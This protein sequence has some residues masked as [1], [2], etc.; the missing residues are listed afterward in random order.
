MVL[1]L[2]IQVIHF[3]EHFSRNVLGPRYRKIG[4]KLMTHGLALQG[5]LASDD[6]LVPSMRCRKSQG[7]FPIL[8]PTHFVAPN[9]TIIGN[10]KTRLGVSIWYGAILRSEGGEIMLGKNSVVHDNSY[11]YCSQK[12]HLKIGHNSLVGANSHLE[13]CEIGDGV[14]VGMS[15][16]I[17]KGAKMEHNSV[18]A[19][20]SALEEGKVVKTR[21][22]WGG[23]PARLIRVLSSDELEALKEHIVTLKD[24]SAIH[25]EE[26]EKTFRELVNDK[27]AI[28]DELHTMDIDE[29]I[30]EQLMDMGMP[31]F[32]RDF[33]DPE[34][35][36]LANYHKGVSY[37]EEEFYE[38]YNQIDEHFPEQFKYY[39]DNYDKYSELDKY[40]EENPN[41]P[42]QIRPEGH[43]PLPTYSEPWERRF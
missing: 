16:S 4:Q 11:L 23:N 25:S 38:T 41:V 7:S 42:A 12:C 5:N 24:L 40:F 8:S 19:P 20:G 9:A 29:G 21:E 1:F 6:R 3:F 10:V 2:P 33:Q 26:T 14:V 17:S 36:L 27:D 13:D 22:L 35:R 37:N 43:K 32:T 18:L 15:S 30:T 28:Y 31:S 34:E 39:K